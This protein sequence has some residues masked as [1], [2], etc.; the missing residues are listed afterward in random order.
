VKGVKRGLVLLVPKLKLG[1]AIEISKL[2]FDRVN[3]RYGGCCLA[4]MT[5]RSFADHGIP[6]LELGNEG[7]Q[8]WER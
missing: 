5:K 8:S 4:A 1:N 6:K 2:S 7:E 3:G